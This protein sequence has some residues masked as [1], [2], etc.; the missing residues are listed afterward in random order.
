M[1]VVVMLSMLLIFVLIVNADVVKF[2]I[3]PLEAMFEKVT[4]LSKDPMAATRAMLGDDGKKVSGSK[5]IH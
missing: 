1:A 5:E 3:Y 2:V 4:M